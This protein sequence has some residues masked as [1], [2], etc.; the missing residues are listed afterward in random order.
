MKFTLAAVMLV[1]ANAAHVHGDHDDCAI[2]PDQ[3]TGAVDVPSDWTEIEWGAFQKCK[4]II[5][6]RIP[7]EIVKISP[8]AFD[9][10][11][12]EV[13][14]FDAGSKLETIDDGAFTNTMIKNI[15]IPSSVISIN[16]QAFFGSILKVVEF[17]AGSKLET[18]GNEAF[19]FTSIKTINIPKGVQ[20]GTKV[21]DNTPCPANL[22]AGN[23][24]VNCNIV[25][26]PSTIPTTIPSKNPTGRPSGP[27]S[28]PTIPTTIP[29]K[30]LSGRPSGSSSKISTG[31]KKSKATKAPKT[32]NS[33]EI[34]NKKSKKKSKAE[35]S[36][37]V[38]KK[39][40]K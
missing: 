40:G 27:S 26:V 39:G 36:S 3:A 10:S 5:S 20:V 34:K 24:V 29:S 22:Q 2:Q 7:M 9:Y 28:I 14:E 6:I 25:A 15:I 23:Y 31:L 13:V 17:E 18:I 38:P 8:F 1:L 21:F 19:R 37:Q 33:K 12:L 35:K 30:N 16:A 32:K 4:T 11:N